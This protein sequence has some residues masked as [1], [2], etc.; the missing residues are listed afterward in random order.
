MTT[1]AQ[2]ISNY[3]TRAFWGRCNFTRENTAMRNEYDFSGA[4][5]SPYTTL[6]IEEATHAWATSSSL[7]IPQHCTATEYLQ[8]DFQSEKKTM[9]IFMSFSVSF[10]YLFVR[11]YT[12]IKQ[13][14]EPCFTTPFHSLSLQNL[15]QLHVHDSAQRFQPVHRN[16]DAHRRLEPEA[17][18]VF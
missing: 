13:K 5:R 15:I 6:K 10:S 2:N 12:N 8:N 9:G 17:R 16:I 18:H 14:R 11:F 7:C 1:I 3:R 4:K